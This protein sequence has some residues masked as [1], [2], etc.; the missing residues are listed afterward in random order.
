MKTAFTAAPICAIL[1]TVL[2]MGCS[3]PA[4]RGSATA[5]QNDPI[6]PSATSLSACGAWQTRLTGHLSHISTSDDGRRILVSSSSEIGAKSS[7]DSR[8]RLLEGKNGKTLWS[9]MLK[10]PVKSQSMS[11]DGSILAVNT[12]DNK[13]AIYNA[14]GRKLWEK[15]H[16]GRPFV[17]SKTK[18]VL[19][20]LDDDAEPK[21]SFFTYDY[22]G[23]LEA[24]VETPAAAGEGIDMF[25]ADDENP[26]VAV[27][28]SG[29]WIFVYTPAGKLVWSQKMPTQAITAVVTTQPEPLLY[30]VLQ[31]SVIAYRLNAGSRPIWRTTLDRRYETIR[32]SKDKV[33]LYGNS[34][35]GQT[36]AVL[37]TRTGRLLWS[38]GYD[39]PANYSSRVF[40]SSLQEAPETSYMSV[41]V[42]PGKPAGVLHLVGTSDGTSIWDAAINAPDGL[43]S[44]A[45]APGIPA[46]VV[47][48]G[49]SARGAVQYIAFKKSCSANTRKVN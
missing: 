37:D 45:L 18:R 7:E 48:A 38:K 22:K 16:L 35:R 4:F 19:L 15:E 6:L 10:Q 9:H 23:R 17:L 5:N 27:L 28:T 44:Y 14:T 31:D 34:K 47:G 21:V 1:G 36:L 41:A 3:N 30:T 39:V 24:T 46:V 20:L 42:D 8:I 2:T 13:L 12:Y 25:A 26:L 40:A 49:D 43:Y 11:K 29:N 33:F 32:A